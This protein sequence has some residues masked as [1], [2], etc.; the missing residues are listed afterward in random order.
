MLVSRPCVDQPECPVRNGF[1][2]GTYESVEVVREVRRVGPK[3]RRTRSSVD[4]GRDGDEEEEEDETA[5]EWLMVTR[6]DPGGSVPR[7]MVEKGTPGGIVGDAGRFVSWLKAKSMEELTGEKGL[8]EEGVE[9]HDQADNAQGGAGEEKV[10]EKEEEPAPSGLYGMIASA[11]EAAGSVVLPRL[12]S[13]QTT[14]DWTDSDMTDLSDYASAEDGEGL[15]EGD[16]KASLPDLASSVRS[17]TSSSQTTPAPSVSLSTKAERE[18]DKDLAKLQERH[19]RA[20]EKMIKNQERQALK[21]STNRKNHS[22]EEKDQKAKDED[23]EKKLRERHEKEVA[24]HQAKF[25][26]D[27]ARLAEKKEAQR[28]KA[29]EK[30]RKA[31]EKEERRDLR[32]EL[33]K[34]KAERDL[35][36]REMEML[37]E[38]VGALQKENTE[39]VVKLGVL[40]KG[41]KKES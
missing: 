35:V 17:V 3:V 41:E 5:I 26:R 23:E 22:D 40:E 1:I 25:E 37:R 30:A 13:L 20:H 39:L 28:K 6:S 4:L 27:M 2:R 9:V 15:E 12:P 31:K 11:L 14:D 18:H 38:Q 8:E 34:V 10:D 29:E 24:K 16:D 33:D 19:R 36:V 21:R 7:F 32:A